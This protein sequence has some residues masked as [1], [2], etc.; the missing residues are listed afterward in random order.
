M[1]SDA[2]F[3]TSSGSPVLRKTSISAIVNKASAKSS[4][5]QQQQVVKTGKEPDAGGGGGGCEIRDW[6]NNVFS[7]GAAR[8]NA[9][10]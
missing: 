9:S 4:A 1:R 5:E 3:N 10:K 8:G 7:N 6:Q 2:A